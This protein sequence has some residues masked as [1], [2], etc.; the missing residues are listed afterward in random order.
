M[1]IS[2]FATLLLATSTL[3]RGGNLRAAKR[4]NVNTGRNA[5]ASSID[6]E[7]SAFLQISAVLVDIFEDECKAHEFPDDRTLLDCYDTANKVGAA[8]EAVGFDQE[9]RAI[10][11][12]NELD[13]TKIERSV[14]SPASL[15]SSSGTDVVLNDFRKI[16]DVFKVFFEPKYCQTF[17]IKLNNNGQ[18]KKAELLTCSDPT[19]GHS[20]SAVGTDSPQPLEALSICEGTKCAAV[21][22]FF[23]DNDMNSLLA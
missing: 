4:K 14:G 7:G 3:A 18:T 8:A 12:C 9:L 11:I 19:S 5:L 20:L 21:N 13:C 17:P 6:P 2:A 16:N 10:G 1:N 15:S 23:E 22:T